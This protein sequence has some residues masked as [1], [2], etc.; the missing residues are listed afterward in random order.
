MST[1]TPKAPT[2]E[3]TIV[4]SP[5]A[6]LQKSSLF[7]HPPPQMLHNLCFS[8][9]VGITAVPRE[10]ENNPYAKFYG[11]NKVHFGRCASGEILFL[12]VHIICYS[13]WPHCY[14]LLD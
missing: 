5:L 9:L 3:H 4:Y 14:F 6:H 8:F 10:I 12:T 7:D 1:N 11:V 2:T 13:K